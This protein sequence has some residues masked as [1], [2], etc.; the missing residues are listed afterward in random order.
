[1]ATILGREA[2]NQEAKLSLAIKAYKRNQIS[3]L[4]AAAK[5]FCIP[6]PHYVM[7]YTEALRVQI[8]NLTIES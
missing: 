2:S 4:R 6:T 8:L 1:M 7:D 5:S 3:T